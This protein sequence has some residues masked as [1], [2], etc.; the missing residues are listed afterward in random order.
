MKTGE[1]MKLWKKGQHIWKSIKKLN[2][3]I[4]ILSSSMFK[5]QKNDIDY[6]SLTHALINK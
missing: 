6:A 1:T 3:Q 5:S 2:N 4:C